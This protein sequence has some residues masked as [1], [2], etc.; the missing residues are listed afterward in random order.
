MRYASGADP[1]IRH[2]AL[3]GD[4]HHGRDH[5]CRRGEGRHT[6]QPA[7]A[8]PPLWALPRK[9]QT[10]SPFLL[11]LPPFNSIE[12]IDD[13]YQHHKNKEKRP[14]GYWLSHYRH[15][16]LNRLSSPMVFSQSFFPNRAAMMTMT[17]MNAG[18]SAIRT[19]SSSYMAT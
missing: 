12:P 3:R 15:R 7:F 18:S 4:G 9:A 5:V 8:F 10:P 6:D 2:D 13:G 17:P 19:D 1:V 14:R 16:G 11:R